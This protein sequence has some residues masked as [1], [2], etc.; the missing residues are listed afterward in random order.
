MTRKT[1]NTKLYH[2]TVVVS[3]DD[4]NKWKNGELILNSFKEKLVPLSEMQ[5]GSFIDMWGY[6]KYRDFARTCNPSE[7]IRYVKKE[8]GEE[9]VVF[10]YN[11]L[12]E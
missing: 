2:C 3:E 12:L 11:L 4:F 10:S 7:H 9:V 8:S 5:N 6:L 1:D